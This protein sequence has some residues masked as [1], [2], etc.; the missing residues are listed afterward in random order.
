MGNINIIDNI[1]R[2]FL[3]QQ[4]EIMEIVKSKRYVL[5]SGAVRAGKTLLAAHVAITTC[6]ENPGCSG[7]IGSLTTQQLND[8]VFKVFIQEL[9]YYQDLIDKHNI[10]II[11]ANIKYS[12]GDMRAE[13]YNGSEI[14]FRHCE[15]EKKIRGKTLD[16]AI[17]DEP[18]EIDESIFKQL[19]QRISGGYIKN[20]FILLT[21][22]PGSQSHWIYRYFFENATNEYYTV[23]TTT[24]DNVLLPQYEKYIKELEENLDDDWIRRFLDGRWGA[25]AGQVYKNFNLDKHTGDFKDFTAVKYFTAGVDWGNTNPSCI[26]VIGITKDKEVIVVKEWY[27]RGMTTPQV[28]KQIEEFH[29]KYHFKK[30][31]IDASAP[32]LI[33]QTLDLKVPAVKSERDVHGRI[34]KIRGLFKANK[35]HIDTHCINLIR[36]LQAYR[37]ERDKL[38]KNKSEEPVKQDDHSPDALGYGLTGYRSFIKRAGIGFVKRDLWDF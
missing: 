9:E 16:F 4:L 29:K 2:E 14:V 35:I 8:V 32:D 13:F 36:E 28:A 26:L 38:N 34:G 20:P 10:P 7:F 3:P 5:Y 17:L 37:Y 22:N 30:V 12:K 27:K 18:I 25:Y 1:K 21:T 19:M 33:L 23:E 6:I 11:L 31:Y 24:Y 15:E